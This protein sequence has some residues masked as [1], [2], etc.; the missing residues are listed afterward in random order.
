MRRVIREHLRDFIAVVALIIAGLAVTGYVLSQQQQ[1]YPSWIPFLGDDRF[2]LKAELSTAQAVTPGQGQTVDISGVKAGDISKV[3]LVNGHAV[4]TML[5][6]P[7]YA[8]L[9]H[10]DATVLLRPR[11]GLQ[12]M[13]IE[14]D[15]G[16]G[17]EA[18]EEDSTIPLAQTEP[19]VNPDQIL[20]SLDGDTRDYLQ[21]L[22][23]A[24]GQGL[25][26]RGKEL[27]AALRR[28]EPFGRDLAKINGLLAER[29]AN[30]RSGVTT[31]KQLADVL[32]R[33][34]TRL[35]EW[36]TAQ[37]EAL[38]GFSDQSESLQAALR[39]FPPTLE[40]TREGLTSSDQLS[41]VLAPAATALIP[42]AQ[43]FAP[44][45]ESLQKFL[46]ASTGPIENQIRP[47]TKQVRKP[48]KHLQQASGPLAKTTRNTAGALTDVNRLFNAWAYDPPGSGE[49]YL[50]WT[51]WLN[52]NTN[53]AAQL[54]DAN[55]PLPR[56]LVLQSCLT[57]RLAE[58]LA[59]A[60]PFIKTLQQ[61][62]NAPQSSIICPLDPSAPPPSPFGKAQAQAEGETDGN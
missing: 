55:G 26:G 18:I 22:L 52:H 28:F 44:A 19:N 7:K 48:I 29:R 13:T 47:F 58:V 25:G 39:E 32:A 42:T 50:F 1:P 43:S 14:L 12:D 3:D 35:A 6:E 34:D 21:L 51:A 4:V 20:A 49:S 41:K 11:T 15:P 5:I 61:Y 45:Q 27:S 8:S 10:P 57:A 53:A 54:Q 46:R 40:A 9:I 60:R 56:G 16:T 2:E 24:G 30:I 17:D 33:S 62:T 31:F 37:S 38:Q 36:V 59:V 23:Q